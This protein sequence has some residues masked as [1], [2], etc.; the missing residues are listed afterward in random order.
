MA[1]V[2]K[3]Q[4][5]QGEAYFFHCPGCKMNHII[6]VRYSQEHTHR[7]GK[8]KPT[9][10]FNGDLNKPSFKPAFAI[11]WVGTEPPQRCHCIIRDGEL[12]YL[13]DT[14]HALSGSRVK[15]R[16]EK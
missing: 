7:N 15:M 11:D 12:I 5:K 9:W 3:I 14:T 1:K 10:A 8:L 2:I 16:D 13:V 4:D 6:P